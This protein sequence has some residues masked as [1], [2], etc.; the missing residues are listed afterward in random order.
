MLEWLATIG[1]IE[2]DKAA[3]ERRFKLS[4]LSAEGY[5]KDFLKRWKI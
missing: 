5:V 4:Q 1:A 3:F 2:I